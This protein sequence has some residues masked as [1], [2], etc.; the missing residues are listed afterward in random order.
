MRRESLLNDRDNL[1]SGVREVGVKYLQCRIK[2]Q[3]QECV[4]RTQVLGSDG[5][6]VDC[7]WPGHGRVPA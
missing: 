4:L 3:G 6:E 1:V 7:D 5:M 2:L